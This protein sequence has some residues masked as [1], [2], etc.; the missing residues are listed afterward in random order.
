MG[1]ALEWYR[2]QVCKAE[3]HEH[4]TSEDELACLLETYHEVRQG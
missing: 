3:G 1:E 2:E 4:E